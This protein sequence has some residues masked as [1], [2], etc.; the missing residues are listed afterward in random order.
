MLQLL[1]RDLFDNLGRRAHNDT[2]LRDFGVERYEASRTDQAVGIDLDSVGHNGAHPH[3]HVGTNLAPVQDT[4]VPDVAIGVKVCLLIRKGMDYTVLLD[5][6]TLPDTHGA[7]IAAKHGAGSYVTSALY[8][9]VPN[10][11]REGMDEGI[12]IH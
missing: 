11:Y 5:V 7:N 9:N 3:Q 4:A 1:A 12:A 6:R 2:V 10:Q 8:G